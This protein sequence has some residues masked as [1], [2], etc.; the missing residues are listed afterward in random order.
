MSDL[1]QTLRER[2][3]AIAAAVSKGTQ[4]TSCC[5]PAACGCTDPITSNLYS[6]S[7]TAG[8]P[9][10][11][12]TASLGCGNPTALI[13]LEPGQTVLD[14]GSGGGSDVLLAARR[15]GP[16]GKAFGLDMTD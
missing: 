14:L 11:A 12:L 6:D 9:A 3:V 15:V 1:R 5:G 10:D 16:T 4:S 13:A 7:E 2:H 8:L